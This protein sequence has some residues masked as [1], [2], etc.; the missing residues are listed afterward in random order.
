MRAVLLSSSLIFDVFQFVCFFS[1]RPVTSFCFVVSR[2]VHVSQSRFR[3]SSYPRNLATRIPQNFSSFR[4]PRYYVA[5]SAVF[6]FVRSPEVAMLIYR[7]WR[8][9][10]FARFNL[11]ITIYR[12]E[13][14]S[15]HARGFIM[16][17]FSQMS[18][19]FLLAILPSRNVSGTLTCKCQCILAKLYG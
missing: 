2:T 3:E 19:T 1:L 18:S 9:N 17:S 12:A 5:S 13:V 11:M 10:C 6:S 16:V 15:A 4:A 8:K 14:V 7:A